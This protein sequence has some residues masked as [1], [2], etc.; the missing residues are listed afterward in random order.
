MAQ[1]TQAITIACVCPECSSPQAVLSGPTVRC[2]ECNHE[3]GALSEVRKTLRDEA[4]H[5]APQKA[6]QIFATRVWRGISRD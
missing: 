5:A 4:R 2:R 3:H 6:E 1:I